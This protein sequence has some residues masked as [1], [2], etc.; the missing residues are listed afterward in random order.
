MR[1]PIL[2]VAARVP[3]AGDPAAEVGLKGA[4]SS[5]KISIVRWSHAS[6]AERFGALVVRRDGRFS[7]FSSYEVDGPTGGTSAVSKQ[8]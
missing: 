2:T 6:S 5:A 4:S 7:A 3:L 8:R 1:S